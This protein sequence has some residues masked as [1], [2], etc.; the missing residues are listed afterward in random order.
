MIRGWVGHVSLDTTIRYA[1]INTR[2]KQAAV[3]LCEPPVGGEALAEN[4][5]RQT[6]EPVGDRACEDSA[7]RLDAAFA[8]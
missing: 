4:L 2:M 8:A 3:Q 7:F 1:E 6:T 5:P